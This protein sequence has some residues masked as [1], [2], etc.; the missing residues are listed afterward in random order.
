LATRR[1]LIPDS[2]GATVQAF[3]I[4]YDGKMFTGSA[5]QPEHRTV[6]GTLI[7]A[8]KTLG[9]MDAKGEEFFRSASRT[10]RGVSALGNV[11]VFDSKMKGSD[12]VKAMNGTYAQDG[13]WFMGWASVP[14]DF[15]P[16]HAKLR[17]YRYVLPVQALARL[18]LATM[19]KVAKL[20]LGSHDF[21]SFCKDDKSMVTPR[22]TERSLES[23]EV[24]T[25]ALA[26]GPA[27]DIEKCKWTNHAALHPGRL[28]LVVVDVKGQSFLWQMV[29]R[30]VSAMVSAAK[31]KSSLEDIKESLEGAHHDFGVL[32]SEGLTLMDVQYGFKFYPA[33]GTNHL[34]EAL[35]SEVLWDL[36]RDMVFHQHLQKRLLG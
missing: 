21:R 1:Y 35:E 29:R 11:V 9:A 34:R 5:R 14:D 25:L 31:G 7:E 24:D 23:V 33:E 17:W 27:E 8:L 22:S 32:P 2:L 10:D 3:K 19:R 4:A 6:E 36:A 16:R 15:K 20:F 28:D 26:L 30:I 18:D 13:L 12:V